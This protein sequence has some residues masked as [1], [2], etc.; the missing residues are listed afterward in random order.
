ML[1]C[2]C[3]G[4]EELFFSRMKSE[5]RKYQSESTPFRRWRKAWACWA[6][7]WRATAWRAAPRV[8]RSSLRLGELSNFEKPCSVIL[9]AG[10]SVAIAPEHADMPKCLEKLSAVLVFIPSRNDVLFYHPLNIKERLLKRKERKK[11]KKGVEL[12]F[13]SLNVS[14][15]RISTKGVKRWGRRCSDWPATRRTMMK[16]WVILPRWDGP[17]SR[18]DAANCSVAYS[19]HPAGQR[20]LDSSHQSVQTAGKWWGGHKRRHPHNPTPRWVCEAASRVPEVSR[21]SP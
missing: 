20:Q 14:T 11:K 2:F 1:P 5:W 15:C 16:L 17:E 13:I 3:H 19:G 9:Q 21:T 7:C 8:T 6:S 10:D 18:W 12:P 4:N